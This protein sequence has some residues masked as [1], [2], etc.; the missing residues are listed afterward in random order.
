MPEK[1]KA[2]LFLAGAYAYIGSTVLYRLENKTHLC[3]DA[4][5]RERRRRMPKSWQTAKMNECSD[6]KISYDHTSPRAKVADLR[7]FTDL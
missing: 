2:P 5:R 4:T 6:S 3:S 7:M 1:C